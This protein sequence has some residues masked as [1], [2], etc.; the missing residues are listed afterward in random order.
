MDKDGVYS[1]PLCNLHLKADK[2][3]A[4]YTYYCNRRSLTVQV[5]RDKISEI[6]KLRKS[7]DVKMAR[8]K[9]LYDK[10]NPIINEHIVCAELAL[11][12]YEVQKQQISQYLE[13]IVPHTDT[14]G[15]T[16]V[17]SQPEPTEDQIMSDD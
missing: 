12:R 5:L 9:A 10:F 8:I 17:E 13:P 15:Q 1:L 4:L 14:Q 3:Y 7:D 2:A 16:V 6:H 11:R